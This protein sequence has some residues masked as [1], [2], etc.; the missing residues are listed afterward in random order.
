MDILLNARLNAIASAINVE[1]GDTPTPPTPS[2]T[3]YL[4]N[5]NVNLYPGY[6]GFLYFNVWLDTNEPVETREQ[7]LDIFQNVIG[8]DHAILC[9]GYIA[10][11]FPGLGTTTIFPNTIGYSTDVNDISLFGINSETSGG[12]LMPGYGVLPSDTSA[13]A[14]I[15]DNIIA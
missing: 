1:G 4:H 14:S 15:V 13:I 9:G 10:S 11:E 6:N 8:E 5:I 12:I 2:Q 3:K 7:L